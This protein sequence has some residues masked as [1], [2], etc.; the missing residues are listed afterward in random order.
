VTFLPYHYETFVLTQPSLEA[1]QKIHKVTTTKV[2]LQNQEGVQYRFS[3][4]V[5][6]N[7]FRISLKISK[8]NNYIPLV[9]GKI[10]TTSSGCIVF[11]S[12][13]LF[14][15]TRMFLIFWSLFIALAGILASYQYQSF[16]YAVSSMLILG[17]I[18]WVT[19]SN[20]KIQLKL[21]RQTLLEVLT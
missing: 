8:P 21:T 4:W 7:R 15:V 11:V 19:W 3:G 12:Y 1:I 17:I 9:V 6:E 16:L 14:P 18:H 5:Q 2:L 20:F 13:K 10:E